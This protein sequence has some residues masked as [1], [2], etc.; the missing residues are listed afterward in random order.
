MDELYNPEVDYQEGELVEQYESQYFALKQDE[1]LLG[2]LDEKED[3]YYRFLEHWQ[4]SYLWAK[5]YTMYFSA[6]SNGGDIL[7]SG[8]ND[9]FASMN[10]SRLRANSTKIHTAITKN[11]PHFEPISTNTDYKSLSQTI[12]L[13]S[14]LLD[15]YMRDKRV[16]RYLRRLAEFALVY[17]EGFIVPEWNPFRG[18]PVQFEQVPGQPQFEGDLVF[19]VFTPNNVIRD[20]E[21]K[22]F[23][24]SE[25]VITIKWLD[26][27]IAAARYKDYPDVQEYVEQLFEYG[28]NSYD[29]FGAFTSNNYF[30]N[31][32]IPVKTF[33]H[34]PF[35]LLPNGRKVRYVDGMVLEDE[36][37]PGRRLPVLRESAADIT[38]L[39]FGYTPLFEM[40]SIQQQLDFLY[41]VI[42]TAQ[43]N[44]ALPIITTPAGSKAKVRDAVGGALKIME[45]NNIT[46]KGPEAL[47][48]L[49]TP[50]EVYNTID[51]LESE[52]D[53]ISGLSAVSHGELP[54]AN[55]SG[56]ALLM[57]ESRTIEY[58][59][60]YEASH[61]AATEDTGT[62]M[63]QL[64]RDNAATP[65][66]ARISGKTKKHLI[67]Q[68]TGDD[69]MDIDRVMVSL[70]NPIMNT[71][72][73]MFEIA[74]AMY[75]RGEINGQQ[76]LTFMKTKELDLLTEAHEAEVMRVRGENEQMMELDI[77]PEQYLQAKQMFDQVQMLMQQRQK[78]EKQITSGQVPPEQAQMMME[79]I[80]QL[81]LE[82]PYADLYNMMGL[83]P[84]GA[85]DCD[86][87]LLHLREHKLVDSAVETPEH[88]RF[89]KMLHDSEHYLLLS[90]TDRTILYANTLPADMPIL[91]KVLQ[92][93]QIIPP[94]TGGGNMKM[95]APPQG[96]MAV[97]DK[98]PNMP[99][100]PK[101]PNFPGQTQENAPQVGVEDL[102]YQQ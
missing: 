11:R 36:E 44:F 94:T 39:P 4:L 13:A 17:G 1:D 27:H 71:G 66:I 19:D 24:D 5:A 25:W 10:V 21:C 15:Y 82:V 62:I 74:Q 77:P 51:R 37:L 67:K 86:N 69:L 101:A 42:T 14:G 60:G 85:K 59:S 2:A 49:Q 80:S 55:L 18:E 29:R 65:R 52:M 57:L 38:G 79:Q 40:L 102:G 92:S 7:I 26:K 91:D 48:L 61:I 16:E 95:P 53:L 33:Y 23:E 87:H 100:M 70:D 83:S 68:F 28:T 89:L 88:I 47:N 41:D 96:G 58:L 12:E 50:A 76:F 56:S 31:D 93:Q 32:H 98:Q 72:A 99:T 84:F 22:V 6:L 8:E 9:E 97:Q 90:K 81:P 35:E 45:Y 75:D 3:T 73:G 78:L 63:I 20:I 43:R 46:D 54:S 34:K 30:R 64:L